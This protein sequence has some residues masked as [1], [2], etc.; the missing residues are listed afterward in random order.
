[1]RVLVS[2]EYD[3]DAENVWEV[4]DELSEEYFYTFGDKINNLKVEE[5]E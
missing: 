3:T 1:M 4:K 5:I 2:F